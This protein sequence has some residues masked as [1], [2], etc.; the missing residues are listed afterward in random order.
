M[1]NNRRA[2]LLGD[3]L[4]C[5]SFY[6]FL[7]YKKQQIRGF[8][9][10]LSQYHYTVGVNYPARGYYHYRCRS[11]YCNGGG[12]YSSSAWSPVYYNNALGHP[13]R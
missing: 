4:S 9:P 11:Y 1:R 8:F 3:S 2:V 10:F 7:N 5:L 13:L 12:Y 6:L